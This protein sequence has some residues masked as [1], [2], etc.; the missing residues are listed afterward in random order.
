ML[1]SFS[2]VSS[3]YRYVLEPEVR[4]AVDSQLASGPIARFTDLPLHPILTL[5]MDPPESW[6]VESVKAV[7]DLDNI[8]M[9]E[10]R[11][12]LNPQ[13]MFLSC[14]KSGLYDLGTR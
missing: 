10:V 8:V 3:F 14:M 11:Y 9:D 6:L 7:Y 12:S 13:K 4:F 5:G 1:K 2:S